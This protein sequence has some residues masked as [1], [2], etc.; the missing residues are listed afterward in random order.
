MQAILRPPQAAEYIGCSLRQLYNIERDDPDFPRKLV[1]SS[2]FVGWRR[3][4][5]EAY[6]EKKEARLL[7][8]K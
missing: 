8:H 2:R 6:L 4:S 3:E 1:F 5:L 7:T